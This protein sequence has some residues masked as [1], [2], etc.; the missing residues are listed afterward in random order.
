MKIVR[1]VAGCLLAFIV[2]TTLVAQE[3]PALSAAVQRLDFRFKQLL[4]TGSIVGAQ[5][6]V[7]R[8]R[9]AT[10]VKSY[11]AVAVGSQQYVDQNTLFLIGSCSKPFASACVLSL[12]DDPNIQIELSD[13]IDRWIPAYGSA[14]TISGMPASR[15][16]T[17]EELMAHRAGIYS[18]K[19]GMSRAQAI[20]I[21]R[22]SHS[23]TDAVDGISQ[24]DLIAQPGQQY[25]YSGAGYCVLGR[26]AEMA[27]NKPFEAILQQRLCK[28]LGLTRTTYFP[29][30][31]VPDETI[32]T[33]HMQAAAPHRLGGEHRMPLIGGSLYSTAEE[34]SQ[35]GQAI[36]L[37]WN[38]SQTKTARP[39]SGD[40]LKEITR[41]RSRKSNYSIGWK[42]Q[43][44]AGRTVR[45]SHS[46]SLQS[47]RAY[48]A[49]DLNHRTTI[50][51]CWTLASNK[52]PPLL[53]Q[54]IQAVLDAGLPA[55]ST[56]D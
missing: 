43:Q 46:G 55:D 20:W 36:V 19:V 51:A 30:R 10:I 26:V 50:S 14:K 21:R 24:Y 9:N 2:G 56:P 29:G 13:Q 16:P 18:Q 47:Y 23:L 25:A 22:F 1:K 28:P 48:L 49:L 8:D 41:I 37:Q 33:G 38:D 15:A 7:A 6:A 4:S 31:A 11:G 54:Q 39:L 5:F 3:N 42:V 40:S 32:A 35:F 17:V 45:L 53:T 27:S 34:M 12:I 52:K 44:N